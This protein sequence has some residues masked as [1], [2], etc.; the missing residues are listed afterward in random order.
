MLNIPPPRSSLS[1]QVIPFVSTYSFFRSLPF[2]R[3]PSLSQLLSISISFDFRTKTRTST[4]SIHVGPL[5]IG[6]V[7]M[8]YI[9]LMIKLFKN[10]SRIFVKT[11]V[12]FESRNQHV[13]HYQVLEATVIL[14]LQ[15]TPFTFARN[16]TLGT[17]QERRVGSGLAGRDWCFVERGAPPF[18]PTLIWIS[19]VW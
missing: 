11:A 17:R 9:E 3:P 15:A 14:V 19:C 12:I 1:L 18:H 2:R 13:I 10:T 6:G 7:F 16:R 4:V 5:T 8:I